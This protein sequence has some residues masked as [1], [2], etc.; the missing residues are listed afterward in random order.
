MVAHAYNFK[1]WD[2]RYGEDSC[3][4]KASLGYV[5]R[6]IRQNMVDCVTQRENKMR[7]VLLSLPALCVPKLIQSSS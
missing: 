3:E 1:N 5:A 6:L 4:F 7:S 2:L